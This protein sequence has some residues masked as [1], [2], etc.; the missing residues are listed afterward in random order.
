MT[1]K[2]LAAIERRV[3]GIEDHLRVDTLD[4]I[5]ALLAEVRRLQAF[6]AAYYQQ[7][8]RLDEITE[9]SSAIFYSQWELYRK[10]GIDLP[11]DEQAARLGHGPSE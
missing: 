9:L 3:K 11:T 4:D 1:E 2:Q 8:A 6:E 7:H 5:A 10:I